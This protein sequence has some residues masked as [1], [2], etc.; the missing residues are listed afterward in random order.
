[1]DVIKLL[2]IHHWRELMSLLKKLNYKDQYP[3]IVLNIPTQ[4]IDS[5]DEMTESTPRLDEISPRCKFVLCFILNQNELTSIATEVIPQLEEDA[6]FWIAYPKKSSKKYKT[7]LS[8]DQG[9]E[10]LGSLGYE[11]V[12]LIS[13]NDD[14]SIIRFRHVKYIKTMVRSETM[15]LTNKYPK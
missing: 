2:F 12:T 1:M 7:D 13:L 4:L 15:K 11:P 6:L 10:M 3:F 14:F 9:W 5:L 8:R